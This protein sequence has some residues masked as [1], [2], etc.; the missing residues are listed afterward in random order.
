MIKRSHVESIDF[1]DE[2]FR[3]Q[4]ALYYC[5]HCEQ[6]GFKI[7][8]RNRIYPEG[9][10]VPADSDQWRQCHECGL[11]VPVYEL[12]K[13]SKIKDVVETVNNPFDSGTSILG[14]DKRTSTGGLNARK[15]KERQKELD[16]IKDDEVKRELAKGNTLLS[17]TEY[18][19]Q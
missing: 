3:E 5:K 11:I 16:D 13:E 8:L 10:P 1:S 19:P 4:E 17:Y 7:P 12:E 2:E 6:F 9:E 15:K 18:Q 14:I